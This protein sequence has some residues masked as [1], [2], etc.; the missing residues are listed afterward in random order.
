MKLM[1]LEVLRL[2]VGGNQNIATLLNV[3]VNTVHYWKKQGKI[4]QFSKKDPNKK[5]IHYAKEIEKITKGFLTEEIIS[6]PWKPKNYTKK[7][8]ALIEE[9]KPKIL[10][11]YKL[12]NKKKGR[13]KK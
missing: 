12:E 1:P 5:Q 3:E 4:P 10:K 7:T 11:K 13:P 8:L 2:L 6:K 9:M